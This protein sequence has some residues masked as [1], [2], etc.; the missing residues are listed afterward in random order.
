MNSNTSIRTVAEPYNVKK[1]GVQGGLLFA[2]DG[3]KAEKPILHSPDL[4]WP[5]AEIAVGAG[6]QPRG[7]C[8][9]RN[10]NELL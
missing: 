7:S 5:D 3:E 1:R 10:Q 6:K 4:E 2:P 8:Y 9:G